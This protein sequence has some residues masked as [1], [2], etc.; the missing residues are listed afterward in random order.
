[1]SLKDIWIPQ[2]ETM[3]AS[4]EIPNV[5]AGAIIQNEVDIDKLKE[6]AGSG[7][8]SIENAAVVAG[9][10]LITLSDGRE[11][12]AGYVKGEDGD[13]P[14]KGIDYWT[15]EDKAEMVAAVLEALPDADTMSFP[16]EETVSEVSEE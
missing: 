6:N 13:T 8:G 11:I 16:L 14:Q 5:L 15:E 9:R 1:M 4:P 7:N 2:D 12:D 10:L 3:D